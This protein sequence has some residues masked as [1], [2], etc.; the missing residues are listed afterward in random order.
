MV[1]SYLSGGKLSDSVIEVQKRRATTQALAKGYW[2]VT[3][4][5][6][7]FLT[8]AFWPLLFSLSALASL[9]LLTQ[10]LQ[11]LDLIFENRQSAVT[12]LYITVLALPQLIALILPLAVFMAALYALNRLNTDSELIVAKAA[13]VSPWQI[14]SPLMRL[15]VYAM[16]AHLIL[17]L[18]AQPYAFREMR[19]EI[20]KVKTDV[21]SQLVTAGEF[22]TP[23]EG[24]TVY[25][26]E[27]LPDGAMKDVLIYDER[28]DA[29]ETMH[30]AQSG[31]L[32]RNENLTFL[33]LKN[34]NV[35][36]KFPDGTFDL[37]AF[38]N[39]QIDL[40]DIMKFDSVLRLKVSDRY[41]NELLRPDPREFVS[42]KFQQKLTAE[43]H[44][45]LATPLYN[46]ALVMLALCFMIRGEH[47]RLGYGRRIT[48]C[49]AIGFTIRLSCFGLTSAAEGTPLINWA[50]Y[51]IPLS[52]IVICALFLLGKRKVRG[53]RKM[54]KKSTS[55]KLQDPAFLKP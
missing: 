1:I 32:S 23:T 39:Y 19:G 20:L 6:R 31:I 53:I 47:Q 43:G 42:R 41:L 16:V 7:Y 52:V 3:L 46:L 12:F 30:T 36:Q 17:N 40:S 27:I 55:L 9:A 25:A 33:T 8:Q 21:A 2:A 11:T 18:W 5:Q 10:S 24:L 48:V 44:A 35:Q 45:R 50:Q 37:V 22:V 54:F 38:D 13:G 28:D 51:G 34:G 15:G 49:A 14:A 4:L 26:R 29:V